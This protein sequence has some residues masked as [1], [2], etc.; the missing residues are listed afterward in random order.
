MPTVHNGSLCASNVSGKSEQNLVFK[1]KQEEGNGKSVIITSSDENG[2]GNLGVLMHA[3]KDGWW[4]EGTYPGSLKVKKS[5]FAIKKKCKM[6]LE[7]PSDEA[8]KYMSRF[9]SSQRCFPS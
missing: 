1:K 9:D 4:H 7:Q 5:W 6:L 8:G 2:P 3:H